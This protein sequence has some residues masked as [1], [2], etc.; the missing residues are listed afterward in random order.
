LIPTSGFREFPG[1]AGKKK[2]FHFE[3][4]DEFDDQGRFFAFGGLCSEWKDPNLGDPVFTFA[5]LTTEPSEIVRPYHHRM[6][7]LVAKSGYRNWLDEQIGYDD[8]LPSAAAHTQG[9]AL[10]HYECSTY[11]NSTRVEGVAC[12]QP[13]FI[14]TDLFS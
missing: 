13:A 10:H 5:I 1:P 3:L 11:G 7:L 4:R 6:P 14:Q 12:I 2:A 8:V 9:A